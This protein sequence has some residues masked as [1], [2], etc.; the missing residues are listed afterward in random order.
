MKNVTILYH[1]TG[2]V[3][4]A[5][6][7]KSLGVKKTSYVDDDCKN[8]DVVIRW[9]NKDEFQ[10]KDY[11]IQINSPESITRGSNK[12]ETRKILQKNGVSVPRTFFS[13]QDAFN[14]LDKFPLIG[15][16]SS[17][18]SQGK[19]VRLLKNAAELENSNCAYYSE[20]LQKEKEF[21]V[22]VFGGK[23]LGVAEKIPE[24][25]D[26][27][28]WNTHRG[29]SFKDLKTWNDSMTEEAV[30]AAQ[31]I[32]QHFSGVDIL[33]FQGKF[34]ICE[35][36]SVPSLSNDHRLNIFVEAFKSLIQNN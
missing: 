15:R 30:K 34:Y 3:S 18:H 12:K 31:V 28:C 13:K 1:D 33:Q 14:R 17:F 4:A 8:S 21:R 32:G 5:K 16:D 11:A 26:S 23:V 35:L 27:I 20:F 10:L 19:G 24:N 25:P 29:A 7:A 2:S 36:N 22:Y 9:G 6:L